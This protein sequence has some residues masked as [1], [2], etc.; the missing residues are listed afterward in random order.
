MEKRKKNVRR[1]LAEARSMMEKFKK[2]H[3]ATSLYQFLPIYIIHTFIHIY[4]YFNS[5]NKSTRWCGRRE[6]HTQKKWSSDCEKTASF[7][8]EKKE[9]SKN[10]KKERKFD[11]LL[12]T[13]FTHSK[14][15]THSRTIRFDSR[16]TF[17]IP[18]RWNYSFNT[19]IVAIMSPISSSASAS[20]PTDILFW[21]SF[22]N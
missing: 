16:L 21:S 12:S 17:T 8:V 13:Q 10:K 18:F 19:F 11:A 1:T 15:H 5:A 6:V 2:F 20:S 22:C 9:R 4:I 14:A 7:S 3:G